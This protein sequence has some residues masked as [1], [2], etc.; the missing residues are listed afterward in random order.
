MV[1]I[2]PAP[3]S[4]WTER[5]LMLPIFSSRFRL[6]AFFFGI[7][8]VAAGVYWLTWLFR[9]D[10]FVV[11]QE[12]NLYP[13]GTIDS[14]LS[15]NQ[16]KAVSLEAAGLSELSTQANGIIGTVKELKDRQQHLQNEVA[17]LEA[18]SK[19]LSEMLEENRTKRIDEYRTQQ[20]APLE[21]EK[22]RL[23]AQIAE[24]E[25]QTPA[26]SG[27]YDPQRAAVADL[28]VELSRHNLRI[29][30]RRLEVA[31]RIVDEFGEFAK[32]EDFEAWKAVNDQVGATLN[33]IIDTHAR[34]AKLRGE[35]YELVAKW[36]DQRTG[37]LGLIDFLYFSLG[38]STTTTFGDIIPN[39]WITRLIVSVQLL[40]SI[41][42]VGLF[43]NS[44]SSG[45]RSNNQPRPPS[46]SVE[47]KASPVPAEQNVQ[48]TRLPATIPSDKHEAAT[49]SDTVIED[50]RGAPDVM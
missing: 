16:F 41:I 11:Q 12:V 26:S 45:Q 5:I 46:M 49:T 48:G 15:E 22:V 38:V 36:R 29:A 4:R 9:P 17:R 13:I 28:R 37:R 32:P 34:Y 27:A 50:Q 25:N 31:T 24:L 18:E 35:A 44:L 7:V 47:S 43:V 6:G 10:S 30:E 21:A 2:A 1:Y 8:V 39:H 3:L 42:I 19:R 14:L 23:E 33:E 20:L 40:A